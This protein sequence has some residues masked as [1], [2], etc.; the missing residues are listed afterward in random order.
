V[1]NSL[2]KVRTGKFSNRLDA[3][4]MLDQIKAM[5]Y[6]DAFIIQSNF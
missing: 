1:V 5:G 3:M 6:T 2:Y 4:N